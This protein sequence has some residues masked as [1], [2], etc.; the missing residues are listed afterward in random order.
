MKNAFIVHGTYGYPTENWIPWLQKKLE[1]DGYTVMVPQFPTPEHQTLEDWMAVFE[2]YRDEMNDET[3]LIG[4]SVGATFLLSVLETLQ[5]PVK[6]TC[7]IGGFASQLTKENPL[8]QVLLSTFV[9]KEFNWPVI[10]DRAGR[11]YVIQGDDDPYVPFEKAGELARNLQTELTI[12]RGGGHFDEQ[13]GH[14]QLPE[15]LNRIRQLV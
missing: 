14:T 15:L 10:R 7:F 12:V 1:A 2:Q 5:T 6:A 11:V 8:L 13:S 9:D 4:H 3:I